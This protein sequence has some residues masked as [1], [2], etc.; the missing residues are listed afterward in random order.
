MPRPERHGCPSHGDAG[1]VPADHRFRLRR[2]SE[3]RVAAHSVT[4]ARCARGS[5]CR[6][7]GP[8]VPRVWNWRLRRKSRTA[9][10][11][12]RTPH[13][14]CFPC[15]PRGS[16][17]VMPARCR[18]TMLPPP[19]EVRAPRCGALRHCGPV[20]AGFAV[21]ARGTGRSRG[22]RTAASGGSP[23][24]PPAGQERLTG[25]Y[26]PLRTGGF[27]FRNAGRVPAVHNAGGPWSRGL[28]LN[29]QEEKF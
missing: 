22:H 29:G 8:A 19:A 10:G 17:P 23:E 25:W 12:T 1:K 9:S 4:A 28:I 2:K 5:P 16:L 3:R 6:R 14:L 24:P 13:R 11:G 21:Q 18:R 26:F 15:A 20:R 7:E 27:P